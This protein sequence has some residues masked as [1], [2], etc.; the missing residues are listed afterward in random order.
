MSLFKGCPGAINLRDA[1]P[2]DVVC[3]SCGAEVEIWSDEPLAR[4]PGCGRQVA[5]SRD[6]S[7][8]DWCAS[9]RQCVG[10]D[11]Y[12]R[13]RSDLESIAAQTERNP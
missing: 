11:K 6:A 2:A 13:L 7:C 4:C 1:R 5:Q 10:S 3:P 8:I 9:A 12:E